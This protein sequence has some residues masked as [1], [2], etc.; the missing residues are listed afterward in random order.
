MVEKPVRACGEVVYTQLGDA[1]EV[2]PA[3]HQRVNANQHQQVV[4]FSD[5]QGIKLEWGLGL[6]NGGG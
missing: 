6:E 1:G 4:V 5:R 2:L 3:A